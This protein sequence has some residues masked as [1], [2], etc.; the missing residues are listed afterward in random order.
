MGLDMAEWLAL[1][2]I[3]GGCFLLGWM[4]LRCFGLVSRTFPGGRPAYIFA[5]FTLGVLLVGWVAF[6]LAEVGWFSLP[7]VGVL[8]LL[9]VLGLFFYSRAF[10]KKNS[11]KL[12]ELDES[13]RMKERDLPNRATG[14]LGEQYFR[15]MEVGVLVVWLLGAGWLFFR[16]HEFVI[17]GADAGVYVN[18]AANIAENGRILIDDPILAELDPALYPALLRELP[19]TE[20]ASVVAPY[21][22]LPGF[23]V[24]D[25]AAGEIT[26]QFF[27]LH[28]VWQ[29]VAY[30]LGGVRAALLMT[31]LWAVGGAL[32]L[33]FLVR[34]LV[35]WEAAVLALAMMSVNALQVW[36]ARYP[37]TEMLT[38]FLMW[39]GLWA[40]VLWLQTIKT[41]QESNRLSAFLGLL[42]GLSLGEVFLVRI[43]MYFLLVVPGVLWLWLRQNGRWRR[44]YNWFFLP[45][46]FLTCHS[47]LHALWQSRPY[48]YNLFAYGLALIQK[49]WFIPA[50]AVLLGIGVLV[51]FG[52]LAHLLEGLTAYR[53]PIVIA[54]VIGVVVLAL[55]GWFIRPSLGQATVQTDWFGGGSWPRM[56]HENLVRLGWYLSPVG[57]ALAVAGVCLT[58]WRVN[59]QT[60]VILVVGLLFSLLYLWRIQAN[61][62]QIYASRRYVPV[63]MP[64]AVFAG[65]YFI[66]GVARF[67]WGL[68]R[69]G[70]VL[71]GTAVLALVWLGAAGLAARGFVSQVDYRG[72]IPQVAALDK[73]LDPNS[74]L[75]FNDAAAVTTG[76]II[77]T[78]LQFLY[79]H[80]VFSLRDPAALDSAAFQTAVAGWQQAGHTVYWVG[81]LEPAGLLTDKTFTVT[82]ETEQL[83]GVYDHKPTNI[84]RPRWVMEI[85]KIGNFSHE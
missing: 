62:H 32:A 82:I 13:N 48:A 11:N 30:S 36:F 84:V 6:L 16:P 69:G 43:D 75:V 17:G 24:T 52:R 3:I 53:R 41:N 44:S 5:V 77:G 1:A 47:L 55:Y 73:Q 54:A 79:G 85:S 39:A 71:A 46:I 58:I 57:I 12:H 29:A 59:R 22:V 37:T 28:P 15:W 78:P 66:G 31:G 14:F 72:L 23:Y 19:P 34:Q 42:A 45:L 60:A 63:T 49:N 4:G 10:Y 80:S 33:Y 2:V 61:P 65:T 81:D 56:D 67:E 68:L 40:L 74:I 27:H 20:N 8:W 83:E 70:Y 9:M 50:A 76:D 26:P 7:L 51:F 18:L 64:F 35:G 21:Y 25:A 38:Q